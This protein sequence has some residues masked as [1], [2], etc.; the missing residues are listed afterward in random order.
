MRMAIP[1]KRTLGAGAVWCGL[2]AVPCSGYGIVPRPKLQLCRALQGLERVARGDETM[3]SHEYR[4][5]MGL[6]PHRFVD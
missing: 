2:L 4:S 1:E 5:L 6:W 3:L